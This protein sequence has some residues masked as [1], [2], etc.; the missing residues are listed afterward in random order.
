MVELFDLRFFLII[1]DVGLAQGGR[2]DLDLLIQVVQLF[3]SFDE[4]SRQDISFI[5]DHLVILHLLGLLRLSL[6]N[7]ILETSDIILL[8]LDHLIRAGNLL[9]DLHDIVSQLLVFIHIFITHVFLLL[10]LL[11]FCRDF[12]LQLLYSSS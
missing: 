2:L 3:I 5:H 10:L 11:V 7:D 4:L 6:T 9:F 12:I 1:V 8:G